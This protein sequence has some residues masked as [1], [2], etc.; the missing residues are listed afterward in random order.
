MA[1]TDQASEA[2]NALKMLAMI[3]LRESCPM[4]CK[5]TLWASRA[6]S[7]IPVACVPAVMP[8]KL[9]CAPCNLLCATRE[10]CGACLSPPDA[11]CRR[12]VQTGELMGV[13]LGGLSRL[14]MNALLVRRMVAALAARASGR[15]ALRTGVALWQRKAG[16]PGELDAKAA[17]QW[18]VSHLWQLG[19]SP[20]LPP[21]CHCLSAGGSTTW[22]VGCSALW[23]AIVPDSY[24]FHWAEGSAITGQARTCRSEPW[25]RSWREECMPGGCGSAG[26]GGNGCR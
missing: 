2:A 13:L 23:E 1:S 17:L 6:A 4:Q 21:H 19:A 11:G 20:S 5:C 8:H 15:A 25:H 7:V 16:G 12:G 26:G 22:E 14:G 3:I 10:R 18:A 9:A 24:P